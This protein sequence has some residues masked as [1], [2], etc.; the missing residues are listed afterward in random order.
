MTE[1][2]T[3]ALPIW[4]KNR[5][6]LNWIKSRIVSV[7]S[8]KKWDVENIRLEDNEK[9]NDVV[10]EE[11]I[12][13][14]KTEEKLH[15]SFIDKENFAVKWTLSDLNNTFVT[16]SDDDTKK[17]EKIDYKK[18]F[19]DVK[20]LKNWN[21]AVLKKIVLLLCE[22]KEETFGELLIKNEKESFLNVMWKLEN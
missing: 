13:S 5:F 16:V 12:Q 10:V 8:K 7:F 22:L 20:Y 17:E 21:V 9:E 14:E 1:V 3:C 4:K 15:E 2:Q 11:E 19:D 18:E 6:S